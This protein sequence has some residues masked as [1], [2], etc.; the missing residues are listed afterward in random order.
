VGAHFYRDL[1]NSQVNLC[2]SFKSFCV[3]W[4]RLSIDHVEDINLE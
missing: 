3:S 1:L 4:E 2:K